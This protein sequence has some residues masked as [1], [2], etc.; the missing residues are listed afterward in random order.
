MMKFLVKT[1]KDPV[2]SKLIATALTA[3]IVLV[4]NFIYSVVTKESFPKVFK[5]FWNYPISLWV[6]CLVVLVA[7]IGWHFFKRKPIEPK[8]TYTQAAR[9]SDKITY[10]FFLKY[11]GDHIIDWCRRR[12]P[13]M[14][15]TDDVKNEFH[16]AHR[17]DIMVEAEFLHPELEKLR[18]QLREQMSELDFHLFI[19]TERN[20]ATGNNFF[21]PESHD[22]EDFKKVIQ[23]NKRMKMNVT[24]LYDSL[25]RLYKSEQIKN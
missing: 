1:W 12:N 10:S 8:F 4:S 3:L 14:G 15:I 20:P 22:E 13:S 5:Q 17:L 2:G 9:D 7:V 16:E 24:H 25:V 19:E 18:V 23:E 6:I 21:N 11:M